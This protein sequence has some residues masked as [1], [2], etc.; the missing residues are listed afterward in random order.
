[1]NISEY[2]D[3]NFHRILGAARLGNLSNS[4]IFKL[5]DVLPELQI[6]FLDTAP[7]YP[8]SEIK[9][10]NFF[11]KSDYRFQVFTKFGRGVG[12]L[13]ALNL[14]ESLDS[15]LRRLRSEQIYGFSIHNRAADVITDELI[16]LLTEL[17]LQGKIFKFGWCGSWD[18]LPLNL[19]QYFDYLMLPINKFIPGVSISVTG[20]DIPII[21]MNPFANFFWKY[22]KTNQV[23]KFFKEKFFGVYN[24]EPQYFKHQTSVLN[25][26]S[27]NEMVKFS[28]G[29]ENVFGLCFGSTKLE[30]ILE[31]CDSLDR[32]NFKHS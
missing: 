13:T 29:F 20:I 32:L 10:G 19:I 25:P 6:N 1:M 5:L 27:L 11:S 28:I 7:S 12:D 9:I 21:A 15:S 23:Q 4:K 31:I 17:K 8:E 3:L 30:H 14:V 16:E 24:P 22:K 2:A 26:P 18:N